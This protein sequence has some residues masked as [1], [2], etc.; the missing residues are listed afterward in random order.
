MS[1]P[2]LAGK[3]PLVSDLGRDEGERRMLRLLASCAATGRSV[4]SPPGIPGDR[5]EALRDAF[6]ATMIDHGFPA[7]AAA[8]GVP[9]ECLSGRGLTGIVEETVNAPDALQT[10]ARE[11]LGDGL[12][13]GWR[14]VA[15]RARPL[16][17]REP[18]R[19]IERFAR[20]PVRADFPFP[21]MDRMTI[22]EVRPN[23]TRTAGRL[24]VVDEAAT[25]RQWGRPTSFPR[26]SC[27]LRTASPWATSPMR[28]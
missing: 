26:S 28:R 25:A 22:T 1:S 3:V 2:D 24:V 6:T 19:C 17:R 27:A 21:R 5:L 16:L 14:N 20:P 12:P 7:A 15:V 4:C 18:A 11:V 8:A 13:A 23:A 10:R 9:L